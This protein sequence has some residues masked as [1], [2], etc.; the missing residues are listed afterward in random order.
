MCATSWFV[1]QHT[2]PNEIIKSD[3]D[4]NVRHCTPFTHTRNTRNAHMYTHIRFLCVVIDFDSKLRGTQSNSHCVIVKS[5]TS[6]AIKA[7]FHSVSSRHKPND[8]FVSIILLTH[9]IKTTST[10]I[11]RELFD[12]VYIMRIKRW[13]LLGVDGKTEIA[14]T[15]LIYL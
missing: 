6:H 12:F 10:D 15:Q 11:F 3:H 1:F 4:L 2:V 7:K 5:D 8:K 14:F 13:H 9:C